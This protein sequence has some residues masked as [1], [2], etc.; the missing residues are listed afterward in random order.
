MSQPLTDSQRKA[1]HDLALDAR[2][3]LTREAQN[4]LEGRAQ[5]ILGAP[6][7]GTVRLEP[8]RHALLAGA[9]ERGVQGQQVIRHRPRA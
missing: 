2:G 1:V 8:H 6:A 4:L 3:L 9:G 7:E 5:E